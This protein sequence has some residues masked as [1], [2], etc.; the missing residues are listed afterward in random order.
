MAKNKENQEVLEV[1][2]DVESALADMA[3]LQRGS[4]RQFEDIAKAVDELDRKSQKANSNAKKGAAETEASLEDLAKAYK[5]EA[6]AIDNV[7]QNIEL[8][9]K[10]SAAASDDE[11]VALEQQIADLKKIGQ[12]KI[13][14]L[15]SKDKKEGRVAAR[16]TLD[17]VGDKLKEDITKSLENF[18]GSFGRDLKGSFESGAK[19]LVKSLKVGMSAATLKAPALMERGANLKTRGQERGGL[20]GKAMSA[21]GTGLKAIGGLA[22][23]MGPLIQTLSQLGP[24]LGMLGSSVMAVVKLLIDMDAK[25]KAFNKDILQSASTTE[26]MGRKAGNTDA[27]FD[28]MKTTLRGVRDAAFSLDNLDWGITANEH[29]AV[30]N[31][32]TQEGVSLAQIHDEALRVHGDLGDD[33]KAV[34]AFAGELTH[35]SVAFSRSFGVPLQ[36]INQ[37]QAEM[38]TELGSGLQDTSLAFQRL[39]NTAEDTGVSANK[40]FA[41]IRGVSQDLS[42]WGNRMEDAVM[43]LGRMNK[44]MNPRNAQKFFQTTMQGLKNMGRT[45]RLRLSLL[46]GTKKTDDVLRKDIMHKARGLADQ[47]GMSIEEFS[48]KFAQGPEAFEG[49]LNKLDKS[50]Q[51]SV[52]EALV[53]ARL[54]AKRANAGTYGKAL[55]LRGVGAA[56]ALEEKAAA[57]SRLSGTKDL[58]ASSMSLGGQAMAEN[59][60]IS[61]EEL[62]QMIKFE[63]ALKDQKKALLKQLKS[64]DAS[65]EDAARA[66]LK[67][68]GIEGKDAEEL[69]KNVDAAGYQDIMATFDDDT[70]KLYDGIGKTKDYAKMQADLTQS[71]T[72][73]F[74]VFMDFMMNAL[75]GVLM[76]I[77][78]TITSWSDKTAKA[79]RKEVL[80]SGDTDLI[81]AFNEAGGDMGKFKSEIF[82]SDAAFSKNLSNT[83]KAGNTQ[84]EKY[85]GD[86]AALLGDKGIHAVESSGKAVGLTPEQRMQIVTDISKGL[87][88]GEAADKGGLKGDQRAAFM[89]Q[90]AGQ[91]NPVHLPTLAGLIKPTKKPKG[92]ASEEETPS[93]TPKVSAQAKPPPSKVVAPTAAGSPA[94]TM[95]NPAAEASTTTPV[96]PSTDAALKF[97]SSVAE[98]N[99]N[100]SKEQL[101]I[102]QSVDSRMDRFKMDTGFLNGPYSKALEGS[103]L[104]AVRTALFEYYLYKDIDQQSMLSAMS[105][106][107]MTGRSMSSAMSQWQQGGGTGNPL[108]AIQSA[109][110]AAGGMV[111]GINGGLAMVTAAAGEGLTSIG[112]GERIVPAG[113]GGNTTFQINVSGVGGQDLARIIEAKVVDGVHEYKRREKFS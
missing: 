16:K 53:D 92:E 71:W 113:G 110:H 93:G 38:V 6:K 15:R 43:L 41:M 29:K 95:A 111:T 17:T 30:V 79:T 103:V 19:L 49:A 105:A 54:Q 67:R 62:D 3:K 39:K 23:K 112:K 75:Y 64:G 66:A 81:K 35:L 107:G 104:A 26:F 20:A 88:L 96:A 56:G 72:E 69:A 94:M 77:W 101:Q 25:A 40:F 58:E 7:L 21:G 4:T 57:I 59:L 84:V 9:S 46:A 27:A 74:E 55:A 109:P 5:G 80:K 90:M 11:R 45:D 89:H 63:L 106:G 83:L 97:T 65:Q 37:L 12:E 52:R 33:A 13:K 68:A 87:S 78:D 14:N 10:K 48:D 99:L 61:E 44:Y 36:E 82:K 31:V 32:L 100:L 51:A 2:V 47:L 98:D 73:K 18:S 22:A 102:L 50:Q 8:L 108:E 86:A 60:G 76:D 1:G 42:L 28:D 85:I 24:I 70:K 34:Q 91:L